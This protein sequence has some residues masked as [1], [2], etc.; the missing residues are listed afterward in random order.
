[1]VLRES[2]SSKRSVRDTC[3]M[4]LIMA[5]VGSGSG[6]CSGSSTGAGTGDG[7]RTGATSTAGGGGLG[8]FLLPGGLPLP[9][10]FGSGAATG[11]AAGGASSL[12]AAGSAATSAVGCAGCTSG[13]SGAGASS[14]LFFLQA[15]F[16]LVVRPSRSAVQVDAEADAGPAEVHH[17][18]V[19]VG[20]LEA[21]VPQRDGAADR[22]LMV[23]VRA[24]LHDVAHAPVADDLRD[25]VVAEGAHR[26]GRVGQAVAAEIE[27]GVRLHLHEG[28]DLT[29]AV[30]EARPQEVVDAL[31]LRGP[32]ALRVVRGVRKLAAELLIVQDGSVAV[33]GDGD[34][35]GGL[36]VS[37]GGKV[38]AD[39]GR[40]PDAGVCTD[41]KLRPVERPQGLVPPVHV[42]AP[43]GAKE[44]VRNPNL[45]H[46]EP[47]RALEVHRLPDVEFEVRIR[48]GRALPA[49]HPY[50]SHQLEFLVGEQLLPRSW[51]RCVVAA[52]GG[53]PGLLLGPPGVVDGRVLHP[54]R[55]GGVVDLQPRARGA[56]VD[57]P[58]LGLAEGAATQQLPADHARHLPHRSL[59]GTPAR[60]GR[61]TC[62]PSS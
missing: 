55:S 49:V 20:Q 37:G 52:V 3:R 35:V 10:F 39:P 7:A 56:A 27:L 60:S 5:G 9:R 23:L 15:F 21:E 13:G 11:S 6:T 38:A 43:I 32:R 2:S 50:R 61:G 41:R 51:E 45:E 57:V 47:R 16:Q 36:H 14:M 48:P 53:R 59:V 19:D 22:H 17:V 46:G 12:A 18:A 33:V 58:A 28:E 34:L 30:D 26:V 29:G 24:A 1:M 8:L 44:G 42:G 31:G 54:G 25:D 40:K 62:G 4:A